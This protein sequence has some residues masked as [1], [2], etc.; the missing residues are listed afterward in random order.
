MN[1][2]LLCAV[3]AAAR[4]AAFVG[5]PDAPARE[6]EPPHPAFVGFRRLAYIWIDAGA[7]QP[8]GDRFGIWLE[9]LRSRGVTDV[10]LDLRSADAAVWTL[11]G[12]AADVWRI[13]DTGEQLSLCGESAVFTQDGDDA[14]GLAER[15]LRGA[16]V[17]RLDE[18]PDQLQRE[19]LERALAILES[20]SD[21]SE[22]SDVAWPYFVLPERA[23]GL[24]ARR[25]FGA[26]ASAWANLGDPGALIARN[27]VAA[28]VNSVAVAPGARVSSQPVQ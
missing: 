6:L 25:L 12:D 15:T 27:A 5:E 24:E 2:E 16:I 1:P 19:E 21:G 9:F 8:V 3:T 13:T 11:H 14:V 28:A 17:A 7:W 20:P 10:R 23:Y 26:A 4:A 22:V 18:H